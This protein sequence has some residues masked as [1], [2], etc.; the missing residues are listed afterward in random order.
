MT[1]SKLGQ[2]L[3]TLTMQLPGTDIQGLLRMNVVGS[4][5]CLQAGGS[6]VII[7]CRFVSIQRDTF[8]VTREH[9]I[10]Y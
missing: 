4:R 5:A 1:S 10:L 6:R 7:L 8:H 2:I 9:L 3:L